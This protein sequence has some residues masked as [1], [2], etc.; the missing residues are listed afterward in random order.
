MQGI[1]CAYN[2]HELMNATNTMN[3]LVAM[4]YKD[5]DLKFGCI[6]NKMENI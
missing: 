2:S 3:R 5:D 4:E 6:N 1:E